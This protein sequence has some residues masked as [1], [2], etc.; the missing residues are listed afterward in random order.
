MAH[1]LGWHHLKLW[2][3]GLSPRRLLSSWRFVSAQRSQLRSRRQEPR[4]TVGV[5]ISPFW[6]PL[7]GI[8]WYLY[9]LLQA[10][11]DRDDVRLRLYGPGLVDKGDTPPP[12]V[13]IPEGRAI[14]RVSYRIPEDFSIVWYWLTD[15]LRLRE[16]AIIA[17]DRNRVLFAPNYFLPERFGRCDGRLVATIHDLSFLVVPE[18]MRESTRIDL[19]TRL[20]ETAARCAAVLTDSEAVKGEIVERGLASADRVEVVHLAPGATQGVAAESVPELPDGPYVLFVGTVE[21]RKNL[22]TLLAA[23][24]ELRR[25]RAADEVDL[26]LV[27]CGGSGWKSESIEARIQEARQAGWCRRLGYVTEEQLVTVYQRAAWLALP[28]LY[29]GFGLPA[30]EAMALGVPLLLSDIP[31][32]REVGGDAALYA[33]CRDVEAWRELLE[34]AATDP[35]LRR[36]MADRA[37]ARGPEF[38]WAKTADGTVAAWRRAAGQEESS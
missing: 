13:P 2:L 11:S 24:E 29:E 3:S 4:L 35:A 8:G 12:V 23:F 36:R 14:E 30:V 26:Q 33:P 17:L 1:L 20:H 28:S 37:E 16:Q 31:V 19:A 6:E 34:R 10:L 21:P 27:L 38:S 32:L 5:D 25:S 15:R 22:A 9:R 18:T 7:T